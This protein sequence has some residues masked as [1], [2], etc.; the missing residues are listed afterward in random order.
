MHFTASSLLLSS[1]P[2]SDSPFTYSLSHTDA[3]T[4]LSLSSSPCALVTSLSVFI[5]LSLTPPLS[6]P[7]CAQSLP[8]AV[9]NL[10]HLMKTA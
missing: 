10:I 3:L 4:S 7:P 5:H 8:L 2:L 6:P 1:P 9:L